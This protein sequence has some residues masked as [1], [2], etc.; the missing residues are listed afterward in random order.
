MQKLKIKDLVNEL[1]FL[2]LKKVIEKNWDKFERIFYDKVKFSNFMDY[3]NDNRVDAHAKTISK[4]DLALL[5][6][7]FKWIE[8]KYQEF[9]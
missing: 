2:D 9:L 3:I 7:A 5:R 6:I 8:D 1:Y 4:D